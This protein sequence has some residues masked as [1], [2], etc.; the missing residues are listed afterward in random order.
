MSHSSFNATFAL[1]FM[2]TLKRLFCKSKCCGFSKGGTCTPF[3]IL[4][5]PYVA[6]KTSK[7]LEKRCF[8]IFLNYYSQHFHYNLGRKASLQLI[9]KGHSGSATLLLHQTNPIW[10]HLSNHP[11]LNISGQILMSS[12][13]VL[14]TPPKNRVVNH[15]GWIYDPL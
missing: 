15:C 11:N 4:E 5:M 14:P 13:Y 8:N 6:L 1:F 12:P 7:C 9:H 10:K 3:I 2:V